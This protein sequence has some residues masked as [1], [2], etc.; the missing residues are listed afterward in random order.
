[1]TFYLNP[2]FC[3]ESAKLSSTLFLSAGSLSS[4]STCET[5]NTTRLAA[6]FLKSLAKLLNYDKVLSSKRESNLATMMTKFHLSSR[7][8]LLIVNEA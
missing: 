7:N 2:L 4:I 5:K 3:N 1:M 8:A 6:S